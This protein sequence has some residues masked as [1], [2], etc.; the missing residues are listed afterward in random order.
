M[1]L[2]RLAESCLQAVPTYVQHAACS[3]YDGSNCMPVPRS[4]RQG[5]CAFRACP[6]QRGHAC[7]HA[8]Y[9]LP[10]DMPAVLQP[11]GGIL[12]PE[13]IIKVRARS[14][15][16]KAL[17][18]TA[19]PAMSF[20][21][22]FS[23]AEHTHPCPTSSLKLP[24]ATSDEPSSMPMYACMGERFAWNFGRLGL[25][26]G[27]GLPGWTHACALLRMRSFLPSL[28]RAGAGAAGT[29][30]WSAHSG[31]RA[32]PV[33]ERRARQRGRRIGAWGRG[34]AYRRRHRGACRPAAALRRPVDGPAGATA[35]EL[36]RTRAAGAGLYFN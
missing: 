21:L 27:H 13:K 32:G 4:C 16:C 22:P 31:R 18:S 10:P 12:A 24:N 1:R 36:V 11:D 15:R 30:A 20:C 25:I 2:Q 34:G 5:A 19:G 8:G 17:Q 28:G 26:H 3:G 6:S 7:M 33:M 14:Q 29:G 35:G 9:D 23:A